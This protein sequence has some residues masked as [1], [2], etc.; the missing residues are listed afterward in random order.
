M[1][2]EQRSQPDERR[3]VLVVDD[4]EMLLRSYDRLLTRAGIHV[5]TALNAIEAFG[6]IASDQ[7]IDVVLADY[8]LKRGPDGLY[9]L[10]AVAQRRPNCRR[11]LMTAMLDASLALAAKDHHRVIPKDLSWSLI[12]AIIVREANRER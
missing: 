1:T 2:S 5:I 9:L 11:I 6:I 12:S 4:E 3:V 10:D 7:P 8:R